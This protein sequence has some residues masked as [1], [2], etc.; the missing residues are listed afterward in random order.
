MAIAWASRSCLIGL[1]CPTVQVQ[2]SAEANRPSRRLIQ[3][4]QPGWWGGVS[5]REGI[6]KGA[7]LVSKCSPSVTIRLAPLF[8]PWLLLPPG[9]SACCRAQ[10]EYLLID[11]IRGWFENVC[12]LRLPGCLVTSRTFDD[13]LGSITISQGGPIILHQAR[14]TRG[15]N[16]L[17]WERAASA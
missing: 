15:Q 9:A 6:G 12:G 5:C 14:V 8:V 7:L 16:R 1:G 11:S 2:C 4:V 10:K 3:L 13:G 17:N